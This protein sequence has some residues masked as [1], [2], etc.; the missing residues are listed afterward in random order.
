MKLFFNVLLQ[1]SKILELSKEWGLK[2]LISKSEKI[3]INL[4]E[5]FLNLEFSILSFNLEKEFTVE[6][7]NIKQIL[8]D[9]LKNI[10]NNKLALKIMS[11]LTIKYL[12]KKY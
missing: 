7:K 8:E 12:F 4:F 9:F 6:I 1:I 5:A 10:E 3:I 11:H 2:F